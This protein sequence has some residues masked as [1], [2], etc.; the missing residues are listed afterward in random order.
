M[1]RVPLLKSIISKAVI[2]LTVPSHGS[3]ANV[4]TLKHLFLCSNKTNELRESTG[5][6]KYWIEWH[7]HDMGIS[8]L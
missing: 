5:T 1:Q 7:S 8:W 6:Q 4:H 3:V 2:Y